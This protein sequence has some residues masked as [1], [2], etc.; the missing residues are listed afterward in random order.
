MKRKSAFFLFFCLLALPSFS[1]GQARSAQEILTRCAKNYEGI[2]DYVVDLQAD[3]DMERVRMPSMKATMYFKAPDK[4]H[5]E[6]PNFALLPREG[7]GMPAATLLQQFDP[8]LKGEDTAGGAQAYKLQLV[9]KD[10]ASRLQQLFVWVRQSDFSITR[11]ET[12]PYQG[13]SVKM[14]FDYV[15]VD[16]KYLLPRTLRVEFTPS[17]KDTA[18]GGPEITGLGDNRIQEMRRTVRKGT[19]TVAFS[20]Y[21]VNTGLSDELFKPKE[22]EK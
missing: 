15:F 9:A 12:V 3:L 7:F 11:I 13:R 5:F 4:I 17:E 10:P 16:G 2:S 18:Q 8:A 22:T 19:M 14:Q 1:P 21:R 20:N 6:S